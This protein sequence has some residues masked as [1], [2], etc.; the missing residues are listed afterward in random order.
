[1]ERET[2][3]P[4]AL[5]DTIVHALRGADYLGSLL[6]IDKAVDE[7]IEAH[8]QAVRPQFGLFREV[9]V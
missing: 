8:E 9:P 6:K 2:G 1:V 5:T 4:A 3:I 7:A